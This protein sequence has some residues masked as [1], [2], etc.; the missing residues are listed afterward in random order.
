M[1]PACTTSYTAPPSPRCP[2]YRRHCI[3][4]D[5]LSIFTY[6]SSTT[7]PAHA[8]TDFGRISPLERRRATRTPRLEG[9]YA[10]YIDCAVALVAPLPSSP[11][12]RRL[13]RVLPRTTRL[14]DS[15]D[16][17][18]VLAVHRR[19]ALFC[20]ARI[21]VSRWG[22]ICHLCCPTTQRRCGA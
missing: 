16:F 13:S 20:T 8:S 18:P 14:Y 17:G 11:I 3:P 6:A 15:A 5:A 21:R 22:E 9:S 10:R 1:L 7:P 4:L 19:C 12:P 2:R